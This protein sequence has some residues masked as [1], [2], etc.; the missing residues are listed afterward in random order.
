LISLQ[1]FKDRISFMGAIDT[2][3]LL[4]NSNPDEIK[5]YVKRIRQILGSR[6][7]ISPS[8]E[9]LL[10]NVPPQNIEAVASAVMD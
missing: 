9:A 5:L 1:K 3:D 8:H 7:I 2:Q 10:P 6:L 4:V